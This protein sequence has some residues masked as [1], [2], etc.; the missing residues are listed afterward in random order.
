ML[1]V[2]L[3]YE[4]KVLLSLPSFFQ[5]GTSSIFLAA[6]C[7]YAHLLS[8]LTEKL[9]ELD[10]L[11]RK[12]GITPLI[13]AAAMNHGDCIDVLLSLGTDPN[14]ESKVNIHKMQQNTVQNVS[15]LLDY[16]Y[17]KN[18]PW[19][20]GSFVCHFLSPLGFLQL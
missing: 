5:D 17:E 16:F 14:E 2:T 20:T 3:H 11:S 18:I 12:D 13:M 19:E 15:S 8:L 9:T 4:N 1:H 7:G 6:R 10:D